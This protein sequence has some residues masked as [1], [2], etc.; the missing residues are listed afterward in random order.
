MIE[1]VDIQR[2]PDD[3]I[4][5]LEIGAEVE[6]AVRLYD[7]DDGQTWAHSN[8]LHPGPAAYSCLT[9]LDDGSL[10]CLYERGDKDPYQTITFARF[11]RD[12]LVNDY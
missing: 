5:R 3:R 7:D 10:G 11:S 4:R 12:W 6:Y 2:G 9:V 1:K 8:V